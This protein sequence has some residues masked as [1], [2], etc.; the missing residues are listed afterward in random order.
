MAKTKVILVAGHHRMGLYRWPH[1][2][3]P[4]AVP[5]A[6][7]STVFYPALYNEHHE[8]EKLVTT[9][10]TELNTMGVA[11]HV[12]PFS[13]NLQGKIRWI[14]SISS[15]GLSD[16][17]LSVHLNS[18]LNPQANGTEVFYFG[19]DL[20][21]KA[22]ARQLCNSV[23]DTLCTTNRGE[24]PDTHSQHSSLGI[25]RQT[26]PWAFLLE[27]GFINNKYDM[28]KVRAKGVQALVNLFKL[29]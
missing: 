20:K 25:I 6:Y 14:N 3:D 24:K 23:S 1:R 11:C 21:S 8:C 19:G 15:N 4:G 7:N 29:F 17:L 2:S 28:E 26:T 9:V 18:V 10:A 5:R 12:C 16:I 27:M 13:Y 22:K